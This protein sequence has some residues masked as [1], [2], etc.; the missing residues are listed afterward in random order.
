MHKV[1]KKPFLSAKRSAAACSITHMTN[2]WSLPGGLSACL[3]VIST[4]AYV[5]A[6]AR[7]QT[8]THRHPGGRRLPFVPR[9]PSPVRHSLECTPARPRDVPL[10]DSALPCAHRPRP[11]RS[12]QRVPRLRAMLLSEKRGA[13][14]AFYKAS[15]IGTRLHWQ[16][17]LAC[18]A[19]AVYILL[20]SD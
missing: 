15:I 6:R 17:S 10:S 8:P 3:L 9:A 5:K 19:S 2:I 4:C 14:G 18:V 16:V 20:K 12:P 13:W 7:A 1:H 11:A